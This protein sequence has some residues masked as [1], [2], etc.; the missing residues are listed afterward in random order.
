MEAV[1]GRDSLDSVNE[2]LDIIRLLISTKAN[3]DAVDKKNGNANIHCLIAN[4]F[5]TNRKE[6]PIGKFLVLRCRS[7]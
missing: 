3:I 5:S 1:C 4:V 7:M 6:N 2:R